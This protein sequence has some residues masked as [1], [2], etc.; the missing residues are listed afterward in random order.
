MAQGNKKDAEKFLQEA[1]SLLELAEDTMTVRN[2]QIAKKA[3]CR[4]HICH[5]STSGSIE[6]V[7]QAKK[8]G[9]NV[10]AEITPHHFSLTG[11]KAPG[12]FNIVNPSAWWLNEGR[13][14]FSIT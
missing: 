7:R 6:A 14:T 10:T 8:L 12:I 4:V 5:V 1:N 11:Q 3:G 2:I 9:L 13:T